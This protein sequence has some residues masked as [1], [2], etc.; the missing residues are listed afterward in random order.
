MRPRGGRTIAG[1]AC[2]QLQPT[3]SP[4]HPGPLVGGVGCCCSRRPRC[5]PGDLLH[6]AGSQLLLR[7]FLSGNC[8]RIDEL[9]RRERILVRRRRLLLVQT[10]EHTMFFASPQPRQRVCSGLC[11]VT[12][13]RR[14]RVRDLRVRSPHGEEQHVRYWSG[15]SSSKSTSECFPLQNGLFW[16]A[17]QRQSARWSVVAPSGS[18][19]STSSQPPD[20]R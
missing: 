10:A 19:T 4:D 12:T 8:S 2:G 9:V 1:R 15:A 7:A 17:P 11:R 13:A 6:H 3:C 18:S 20:T 5:G 14:P 16:L